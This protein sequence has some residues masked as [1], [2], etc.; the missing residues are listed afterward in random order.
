MCLCEQYPRVTLNAKVN[1][2]CLKSQ[3]I[4]KKTHFRALDYKTELLSKKC[5][6]RFRTKTWIWVRP[7]EKD[8]VL[9][10][11]NNIII[12]SHVKVLYYHI[13]EYC[14]CRLTRRYL[15]TYVL[16]A[17]QEDTGHS[18]VCIVV[19]TSRT[20]FLCSSQ[21]LIEHFNKKKHPVLL[22]AEAVFALLL[23][24]VF[25]VLLLISSKKLVREYVT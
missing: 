22:A 15:R 1:F 21:Q 2:P 9:R 5:T 10:R 20:A 23:L 7:Q 11:I 19:F 4:L 17:T 24:S 25:L 12:K 18:T 14:P 3:K 8:C 13:Y 6:S 16:Y